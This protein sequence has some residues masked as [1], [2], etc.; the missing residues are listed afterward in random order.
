MRLSNFRYAVLLFAASSY[1]NQIL[2]HSGIEERLSK[3]VSHGNS[4]VCMFIS[5]FSQCA[6]IEVVIQGEVYCHDTPEY[7]LQQASYWLADQQLD[8]LPPCRVTPLNTEDLKL[9]IQFL[10][11]HQIPFAVKSGGHS[12]LPGASNINK[13]ITLDLAHLNTITLAKDKKSIIIQPAATWL[14]VLETLEPHGLTVVAGR[15]GSVGVGGFL[16][17]GGSSWLSRR[18]GWACDSVLEFEVVVHGTVL[19]SSKSKNPDLFWALKGGGSNFGIITA[20]RLATF[21]IGDVSMSLRS[22]SEE[23]MPKTFLA[24]EKFTSNASNDTGTSVLVSFA[25]RKGQQDVHTNMAFVNIDNESH[26]PALE[27]FS[28]I[29]VIAE[30]N[31]SA[32]LTRLAVD[33]SQPN[34]LDSRKIKFSITVENNATVL[35]LMFTIFTN[36]T[37]TITEEVTGAFMSFQPLTTSHVSNRSNALGLSDRAEP[38]MLISFEIYWLSAVH[39]AY[40][41]HFTRR[42]HKAM[43]ERAAKMQMLHRFVY[44]NYAASWQDPFDGY[45]KEN[46]CRLKRIQERLRK[47]YDPEGMF[48]ELMPGGK[49][50]SNSAGECSLHDHSNSGTLWRAEFQGELAD[51]I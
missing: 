31:F 20:V 42:I 18:Y 44:L 39:N 41:E 21:P 38:L 45:G 3:A 15:A 4:N 37:Q 14:G 10:G 28:G 12:F 25:Y 16:L 32:N 43:I 35:A 17:G 51:H 9:S 40:F 6:E 36:L 2:L 7:L 47:K 8:F 46:I 24:L 49:R 19:T 11:K 23:E 29:P 13:G 27:H 33:M 48:D 26:P 50:L 1:G 5:S 22:Y 30:N 34:D